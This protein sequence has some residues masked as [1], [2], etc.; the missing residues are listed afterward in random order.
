MKK[1]RVIQ[2]VT[3]IHRI[4]HIW[5][6]YGWKVPFLPFAYFPA[7]SFERRKGWKKISRKCYHN[8]TVTGR[9]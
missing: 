7:G 8:C 6:S 1:Y 2:F 9:Y 3:G 5:Y 4:H